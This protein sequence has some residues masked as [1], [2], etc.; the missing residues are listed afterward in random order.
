MMVF[1]ALAVS[2][3][4]MSDLSIADSV[5]ERME[6]VGRGNM[7]VQ[8][9]AVADR[10]GVERR[11]FEEVLAS[12]DDYAMEDASDVELTMVSEYGRMLKDVADKCPQ[13]NNYIASSIGGVMS[14]G[15]TS[16]QANEW[17]KTADRFC[18]L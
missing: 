8:A 14:H 10:V 12:L 4:S 5:V 3:I 13:A 7:E 11:S 18:L 9:V 1:G 17:L 6:R 2:V 16:H 15:V